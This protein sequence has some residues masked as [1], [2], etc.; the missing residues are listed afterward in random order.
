MLK[1]VACGQHNR[2]CAIKNGLNLSSYQEKD[3]RPKDNDDSDEEDKKP[4]AVVKT[5]GNH[6]RNE[7]AHKR[8]KHIQPHYV[9]KQDLGR[10]CALGKC[11]R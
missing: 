2:D 6:P 8:I 7:S 9:A 1:G 3:A 11:Y 10:T 5:Y 4:A